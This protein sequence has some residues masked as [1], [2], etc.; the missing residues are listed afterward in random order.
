[1][2]GVVWNPVMS[3]GSGWF[4][5]AASDAISVLNQRFTLRGIGSYMA[6]TVEAQDSRGRVRAVVTMST[7]T[8]VDEMTANMWVC[9][10]Q[11]WRSLIVPAIFA[12]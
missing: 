12:A 1:M 2:I 7:P 10:W 5:V 3:F 11:L 8:D 6:T 4:F 9:G